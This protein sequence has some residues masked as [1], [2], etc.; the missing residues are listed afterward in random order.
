MSF[1]LTYYSPRSVKRPPQCSSTGLCSE[2]AI[3]MTRLLFLSDFR[4]DYPAP[5][6]SVFLF[7][8]L[9]Q[10]GRSQFFVE[11]PSCSILFIETSQQI[12]PSF[13]HCTISGWSWESFCFYTVY[14]IVKPIFR[15]EYF[16]FP[17]K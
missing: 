9:I 8:F 6:S 4:E 2:P 11:I 12:I 15:F 16:Y 13:M 10:V 3:S 17:F 14:F 7:I 5:M 1:S